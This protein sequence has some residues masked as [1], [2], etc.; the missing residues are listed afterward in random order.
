MYL[1]VATTLKFKCCKAILISDYVRGQCQLCSVKVKNWI[2]IDGW[3]SEPLI[4]NI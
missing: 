2:H 3:F 1:N 4:T